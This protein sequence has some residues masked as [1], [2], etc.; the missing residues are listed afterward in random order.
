MADIVI[1]SAN[2]GKIREFRAGF[3]AYAIELL[4]QGELGIEDAEETGATFVENAIIKA[5]HASRLAA[6]AAIADDSGL[7]VPSLGGAPGVHS[8][9]YAGGH[10]NAAANNAK[11]LAA[12]QGKTDRR[13]F[14][15]CTIAYFAH[16]EDPLP[17]IASGLWQGEISSAP[18]G[19]N[20]FGY[21][22]LFWLAD[23]GRSAAELSA[24]EKNRRSHR[25]QAIRAFM[26]AYAARYG[27][28]R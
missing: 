22:P 21:D 10:G 5:R 23:L 3:S 18:R 7:C 2:R 13:A 27:Q 24:A 19:K 16:G 1:A 25:G 12:L 8:A 20:G 6:K 28:D 14:F 26:T 15:V 11:L 17:V 4:P 9:R